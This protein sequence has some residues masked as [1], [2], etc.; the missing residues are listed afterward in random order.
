MPDAAADLL[1][2]EEL[3]RAELGR[4]YPDRRIAAAALFRITRLS[5]LDVDEAGAGNLLQAMEE[6]VTRRRSNPVSRVEIESA[7]PPGV[8]E[9]LLRELRFERDAGAAPGIGPEVQLVDGLLALRSL[10]S[11]RMWYRTVP[12]RRSRR[13]P[14]AIRCPRASRS[15]NES[16]PVT[17]WSTIPMTTSKAPWCGS[18]RTRPPIPASWRSG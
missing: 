1:P 4:V 5:D 12:L 2:V 9:T 3:V 16:G 17:C 13:S 15:G 7:A 10:R 11:W 6:D 14:R 8:L 18:S